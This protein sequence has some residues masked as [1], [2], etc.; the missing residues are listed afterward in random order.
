[1]RRAGRLP[2][3]A[4]T[5]AGLVAAVALTLLQSSTY[6]ADSSIALVRQGQP[7]GDGPVL[8]KAARA[9]AALFHSRAVAEPA[10][11]N[12]RLEESVSE[13]LE[14]FSVKPQAESSLVRIQVDAPSR[15]DARRAAQEVAEVATVLFNDHYGPQTVA[16]I[17]ESAR[18]RDDRVAPAPARN[19]ALG[20]LLG[21]LAGWAIVIF[22]RRSTRL[23]APRAELPWSRSPEPRPEAETVAVPQPAGRLEP[24]P[25]QIPDESGISSQRSR[26]SPRPQPAAGPSPPSS[27]SSG[28]RARGSRSEWRSSA[29]TRT[30]SATSQSRTARCRRASCC[31]SKTSLPS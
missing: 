30:R 18:A 27:D 21:A 3:L 15:N 31:S 10:I 22:R 8:A 1:M 6:R 4:G 24:S 12:L 28:S 9:A 25:D 7:P 23:A 13:F 26:R 11:A 16:S 14:R 19:L 17:W 5:A 20:G 29:S 2:V